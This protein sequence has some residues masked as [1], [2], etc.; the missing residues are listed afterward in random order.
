MKRRSDN[1]R[2]KNGISK[3]LTLDRRW[4]CAAAVGRRLVLTTEQIRDTRPAQENAMR[5]R[6][7]RET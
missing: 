6:G 4:R 5:G 7:A 1:S 2:L 3:I